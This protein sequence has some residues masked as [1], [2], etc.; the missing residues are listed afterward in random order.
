MPASRRQRFAL[1]ALV[2]LCGLLTWQA[3]ERVARNRN[4]SS[5]S[6]EL[7]QSGPAAPS[8]VRPAPTVPA[9]PA[10]Q[11]W[12]PVERW[13]PGQ[14]RTFPDAKFTNRFR[15]TPATLDELV[16]HDRALNLR[17][18]L[19]DTENGMPLQ[20]PV[21]LEGGEDPGAY[22]VQSHGVLRESLRRQLREAGME[23]VS[24]IPN[25]AYLVRG[26]RAAME[27][28][29][30]SPEVAAVLPF[31]PAF[32]LEPQ[33]LDQALAELPAPENQQLIVTVAD[34]ANTVPAM[35]A[36]GG[37]E[38]FRERGP[39]G[40]L[41]T[42]GGLGNR[43]VELAQL[44]GVLM[45]ER[46]NPRVLANDLAG[47]AL[48]SVTNLNN[49][50]P[51][52]ELDGDGVLIN[53]NDSGVD[54]THP[55]LAGRV[56]TIPALRATVLADL[57]GHGTHVAGTIAGDGTA[58]A[59]LAGTP[60]GS[61][62]GASVQGRV[63]KAKLWVLPVDLIQGP[64]SG[65]TYLQEE[66][67]KAPGRSS[68][69]R[70]L[71][72][73]NSW[74][75]TSRDYTSKSASYDAAVR[76][77]LPGERGDQPILYVF[78]AGNE[79]SGGDSGVGGIPDSI[80]SPGNA[81]NVI[82]VGALES[83][84]NLTNAIVYDTNFIAV[85]IGS[86]TFP[87]RGYSETNTTYFTN[88]VLKPFT[89]T[90][91]QVAGF[92]SRGNVGVEIEGSAGRFKPDVVA[93]GSFILSARSARWDLTNQYPADPFT[94]EFPDSYYLF[95]DLEKS[96]SPAY[97]YESGT[98][99]AAPA[100]SGLLAQMQQYL[101]Q[102]QSLLPS[103]ATYKAL[104]INASRAASETYEPN[105]REVFNYGGWG[106]PT[107]PRALR[108][109][110][111]IPG[112]DD[113]LAYIEGT[114]GLATGEAATFRL[115]LSRTN[116]PL[117]I[118]LVWTDPP[119]N[120]A[121]STKLVND[122]D[123]VVSN[124]VT[125]EIIYGN[126]FAE[127]TGFSQIQS[128]NNPSAAD[129]VNNVERVV[130]GG[131]L[132][133]E[134]V[135]FVH[136]FRINVNSR[137]DHPNRVV[138]DFSIALASDEEL[139]EGESAGEVLDLRQV[140]AV[141]LGFASPTEPSG[142]T[143][144]F[145]LFNQKAGANSPLIGDRRGTTNQW[146]FYTFTN[147]PFVNTN[148]FSI[149]TNG[150]VTDGVAETVTNYLTSGSNVAFVV[151]PS[152]PEANLSR[153]RTNGPD[154][155][156]YV[157]RDPGL[158]TL[159]P[160][161]VAGAAKSR[162][163]DATELLTFTNVPLGDDV[164]FYVGVKSED[165]QAGEFAFIGLSTDQPF[166]TFDENGFPHP[167]AIQLRQLTDG[168]PSNP[169]V[170]QWLAISLTSDELRRVTPTVST[171]HENFRDLL[172]ELRLRTISTVLN[173]H[174]PLVDLDAGTNLYVRYDDSGSGDYSRFSNTR[175]S[176]GPGTLSE[177]M[178]RT[179]GGAWF[180]NTVDNAS[181][182]VGLINYLDLQL[183]PNDFGS[184]FVE[185]CVR[186][187]LIELEVIN[188][189]TDA[190]RLTITITNRQGETLDGPLEIYVRRE[191]FPD[192]SNPDNNDKYATVFPPGGGELTISIRDVPPLTPG[193][194]FVAVYNPNNFEVCYR[195][196]ARVE[197]GLDG[198]LTK[199]FES[200]T[201]NRSLTDHAVTYSAVTVDDSR[202]VTA[203]GAG[204]R[205]EHPR[206]SDL[207][208]RL[209]NPLGDSTVLV[210]NRGRTNATALGRELITTNGVFAHVAM[211]FERSSGRAQIYVNGLRVAEQNF[212]GFLPDTT[213]SLRF[214]TDGTT[215]NATPVVLDD[216]GLWRRVL[217][218]DNIRDI[219]R[220]GVEDGVGKGIFEAEAGLVALWPFDGTGNELVD[221]RN[222]ALT[223]NSAVA[224]LIGSAVSLAGAG[225]V[226]APEPGQPLDVVRG[227]GFTLEGWV[228]AGTNNPVVI[229]GWSGTNG[230]VG[231]VLVAN[232]P[233]PIGNGPG[234]F[235]VVFAPLDQILSDTPVAVA[236]AGFEEL[237]G[238]DP[239]H[240]GANGKLLPGHYS[241]FPG[242]P[243]EPTGFNSPNAIP[244]WSS[245]ASAGTVNYSGT[246]HLPFG[247]T[248]GQNCA[249]NNIQGYFAQ[250]VGE[251]F[252]ANRLY[253]LTVDVG[254]SA[255]LNFPGYVVGLYSGGQAVAVD[256]NSKA[257][258]GGQFTE[259]SIEAG[260]DQNSSLVGQ[261]IEIRLGTLAANTEQVLFDNVRLSW[262][263]IA[264]SGTNASSQLLAT[265]GGLVTPGATVTNTLFAV[266]SEIT[267]LN[268][269]L[270]KLAEPPFVTDSRSRLIGA[271][272][273]DGP[274]SGDQFFT[275]GELV[276]GW[277]VVS[278]TVQWDFFPED[279]LTGTS[280]I[281]MF[282]NLGGGVGS[283]IR[284]TFP[285]IP[286]RFYT[287]SVGYRRV[288]LSSG[289]A[290]PV[291]VYAD[292]VQVSTFSGGET[293]QT[294]SSV[295]QAATN[296]LTFEIANPAGEVSP[297][298]AA[299]AVAA[300]DDVGRITGITV[301]DGGAGYVT[302]PAV[303]FQVIGFPF[304]GSGAAARAEVENGAVSRIVIVRPGTNYLQ[305]P[306][307][308]VAGPPTS[309]R[310]AETFLDEIRLVEE[311]GGVYVPEEPLRPLAR[312]SAV[313]QWRLEVTDS[314][315]GEIGEILK[316]QMELTF[317][318]TNPPAYRLTQ[319]VPI[320]TNVSGNSITYFIVEV[321]PEVYA[322][323][324]SLVSVTGGPLNLIYS[325]TG[326]P[327][328]LQADDYY[329]LNGVQGVEQ[330][331]T[332]FTNVLPQLRPGQ[333][334]YLGV[335]NALPGQNNDFTI[336]LDFGLPI[337]VLT[338][339]VAVRATNANQG[340][341]D[342]YSFDVSPDALGVRFSVSN[343]TG[344]VNLVVRQG[345]NL[346]TRNSFDYA[347]TNV[348]LTGESIVIDPLSVPVPLAPGTWYLGVYPSD[349]NRTNRLGYTIHALEVFANVSAL[350]N[351]VPLL[352]GITNNGVID[353]YYID[354]TNQVSSLA[355][356]LT[357]LSGNVDLFVRAGLPLPTADSFEFASTNSGTADEVIVLSGDRTP[358]LLNPGRW[359][360]AV[361]PRDPLPVTYTVLANFTLPDNNVRF[362]VD[363]VPQPE[364]VV[365]GPTN[366]LYRFE[367]PFDFTSRILFE[368]YG[369]DGDA[370]LF[371]SK[372]TPPDQSA[373]V[374]RNLKP[375]LANEVIVANEA[376]F[377][378]MGGTWFVQVRLPVATTNAVAFT[379]RAA[380]RQNGVLA[381]GI[382][383]V[384]G[385]NL[386]SA[387]GQ[388]PY[389]TWNAIPGELYQ[390]QSTSDLSATPLVWRPEVPPAV[391]T[392][393][394]G[395]ALVPFVDVS[396][397]PNY[398]Y[399]VI[400]L[401]NP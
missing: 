356:G 184:Q 311:P 137:W 350:T 135:V 292:G 168:T 355:L 125:G 187:R 30:S 62:N 395:L 218:A 39:F 214:G 253:R 305:P 266:F 28:A 138:Q 109:G 26:S 162:N 291:F 381:S 345:P 231:P 185:R 330:S 8:P 86:T 257:V 61:T 265:A 374:L 242:Y 56:D 368:L 88:E 310:P 156:L 47:V 370:D 122:L 142:L 4:R 393:D 228:N 70:P 54:Q 95:G 36:L 302:P 196:R 315:A 371:V 127:G 159:D 72:S 207:S 129:R 300:V 247:P 250:T 304:R 165:Q 78:S 23:I 359:F 274:R 126:D 336:R 193:R 334:Y 183:M 308:I 94:G 236:N 75:Y 189:P 29:A 224:G 175:P 333:R 15:N 112:G 181:G 76:D 140:D 179:G 51:Y 332:L 117:R 360:L 251:R 152:L 303:R 313:G 151:F 287:L 103:V 227:A 14:A 31:A 52:L 347:G 262:R 354:I 384:I 132:D 268:S 114:P 256:R 154:L 69:N 324:N 83:P 239:V 81:K 222:L 263:P 378:Q 50:G 391:V 163:R 169:G 312:G 245:T 27:Q 59:T 82:T 390:V 289:P 254:A 143:N 225:I 2:L 131:Q 153:T 67:A 272:T 108:S 243:I 327:D 383:T 101:E 322:A 226:P 211:T 20:L 299:T 363:S 97:R 123:L 139:V 389:I 63:P 276:D 351:G 307:V 364:S 96:N 248:E 280:C 190:S 198:R 173:N 12:V 48:G 229:A 11:K 275:V 357:N 186:A 246:M 106:M 377:P 235:S 271:S 201:I 260:I 401:P 37:T 209:I 398:Y 204:L 206:L 240:F 195:I 91:H 273:F 344:D 399:R 146:R 197:R 388:T 58:S 182:N 158:L 35:V 150:I 42:V 321:P 297:S 116:S 281:E 352:G 220:Y 13:Q 17:N 298:R 233:P 326:L 130:L 234:S 376:Q 74:G 7:A 55:D 309:P 343:L 99:M 141:T 319:G 317:A 192:V 128:T 21:G 160:A 167:L 64:P 133:G 306:R 120:P 365:G 397:F 170:G 267:N 217:T 85:K 361:A 100:I 90:A 205:I 301:V 66:A 60:Q 18:A 328:G 164:V 16:R 215:G 32:K 89:D 244:G 174:G 358:Q 200:G 49:T 98:S 348:G 77:A 316:W 382:P 380:T 400:Q 34:P 323:T 107:L 269:Q 341:M 223:G 295:V 5:V 249:W 314:R 102:K 208:I 177:F 1:L 219:Y 238:T 337:T 79:G 6:S 155:D 80:A 290:S 33:L 134:Y 373:T 73:N 53:V 22:V 19:V 71:I 202:P 113:Q 375:G 264:L 144:G 335:Q 286:G 10:A 136:G 45:I 369:L 340:M 124:T 210:E 277:T 283:R 296:T 68:R 258:T 172:G 92:S 353:Y 379:V 194:Y 367:V 396:L 166:T 329:L 394:S 293:W 147:V 119:G 325:Q 191:A 203:I 255:V 284:R 111:K 105:T 318:P 387:A 212:V 278:N 188:I 259:V 157:S 386:P 385:Y 372:D 148:V 349:S 40:Q 294:N 9:V 38:V 261:P 145:P 118:T 366:L 121:A 110:I 3:G 46:W 104:L 87:G 216:F 339:D 331:A 232:Y 285:T 161:A 241:E 199:S 338:N 65:D 41:V 180:F 115:R 320:T 149:T 25:N 57:E 24:Y 213:N 362:L 237:T 93:P 346:P 43:L 84:R 279:A 270:I 230:N 282:P 221:G 342:F 176:D 171:T 178:G 44:P 288:P 392:G 252:E